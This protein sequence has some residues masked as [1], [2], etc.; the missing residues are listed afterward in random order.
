MNPPDKEFVPTHEAN[1][2]GR[3]AA[4]N[5]MPA[6]GP[7][8]DPKDMSYEEAKEELRKIV[9]ALET[10]SVPLEQ[11]LELWKRGEALASRCKSILDDAATQID[12]VNASSAP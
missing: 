9:S 4:G 1:P 3:N 8:R 6:P 11:T 10:G 2:A 5:S 7:D 12:A